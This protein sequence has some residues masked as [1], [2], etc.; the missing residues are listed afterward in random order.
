[1]ETRETIISYPSHDQ[2]SRIHAFIW[3]AQGRADAQGAKKAKGAPDT[4]KSGAAGGSNGAN[5][6]EDVQAHGIV[7]IVHGA[8]EHSER[9]REFAHYLV[10]A[11]FV[12]CA[13]DHVGHGKS[14]SEEAELGHMP[15]KGG[16]EILLADVDALR[17]NVSE[18]YPN[19]PYCMLGHSMGSFILRLYLA[20][21]AE[22][23]TAAILVG[24]GQPPKPLSV[25]GGLLARLLAIPKGEEYR[26]ALLH[27]LGMGA[28]TK[29]VPS[30]LTPFDWISTDPA[31]VNA[32]IEDNA[33]GAV[34]SL[35]AYAT[36]TDLTGEMVT[37]SCAKAVPDGLSL[38]FL[39]GA[40]DP[41]G[42]NGKGVKAAVKQYCGAGI[43]HIGLQL[44]DGLRHEILNE[45]IREKVYRD[46]A[47]WL[48]NALEHK[49]RL[50]LDKVPS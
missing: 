6:V 22:G 42:E 34:F 14:V 29:A 12:V 30:A 32:Y 8:A 27:N 20:R 48:D 46:I 23:V 18:R 10:N 36:M 38:L 17:Q 43:K 3:E 5:D 7:Q 37:K 40:E 26:S 13:N 15:I 50:P 28:Y 16:K 47:D 31:V 41:V 19:L 44:Y 39:S 9:Y 1:M 49:A 33:C 4:K 45:P 24:T 11:G 35:G 2:R 25:F 21:H